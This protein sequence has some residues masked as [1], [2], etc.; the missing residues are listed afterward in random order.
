MIYYALCLAEF[1]GI[2]MEEAMPEKEALTPP[3]SRR[4]P[5]RDG[6]LMFMFARSSS[7]CLFYIWKGSNRKPWQRKNFRQNPRPF[8]PDDQLHLHPQGDS[9]GS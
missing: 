9:S 3:L 8:G 1:Y 5:L 2:D 6:P 7:G 4:A